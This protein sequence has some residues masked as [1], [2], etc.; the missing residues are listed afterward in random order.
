MKILF[1]KRS[2]WDVIKVKTKKDNVDYVMKVVDPVK[3][4]N[5][6]LDK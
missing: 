5:K 6:I 1:G 3:M 2:Q 4:K